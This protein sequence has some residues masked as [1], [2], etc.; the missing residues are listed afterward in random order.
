M[1]RRASFLRNACRVTVI[2]TFITRDDFVV[3][4]PLDEP[5]FFIVKLCLAMFGISTKYI[6]QDFCG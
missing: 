1:F 5:Y 3:R 4:V 6:Q 2:Q